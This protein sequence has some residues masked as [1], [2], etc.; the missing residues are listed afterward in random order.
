MWSWSEEIGKA[1]TRRQVKGDPVFQTLIQRLYDHAINPPY[2]AVAD[3]KQ[4]HRNQ[5]KV[6]VGEL[7]EQFLAIWLHQVGE[8]K[9]VYRLKD[10]PPDL[11][12]LLKIGGKQD[13]GIDIIAVT[14]SD[15]YVAIQ[16]KFIKGNVVKSKYGASKTV[17]WA[18]LA[19]FIAMTDST[20]PWERRIIC[21]NAPGVSGKVKLPKDVQV[22]AQSRFELTR[23]ED[24]IAMGPTTG[25]RL[26][27]S[28]TTTTTTTS[29]PSLFDGVTPVPY[30]DPRSGGLVIPGL[31]RPI[32]RKDL[33]SYATAVPRINTEMPPMDRNTE[34]MIERMRKARL[35]YYDQK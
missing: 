31:P 32:E 24:W 2:G 14:R 33:V 17:N 30:I 15:K 7:W 10:V 8:Y 6:L 13:N 1:V 29:E 11:L 28:T 5:Y 25:H 22:L 3:L 18:K 23:M 21:T 4:A 9:A 16:A 35:D 19:T 12:K 26:G 20:G 27:E 34:E